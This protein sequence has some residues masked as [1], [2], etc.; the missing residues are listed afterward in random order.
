LSEAGRSQ[1]ISPLMN[2]LRAFLLRP[3]VRDALIAGPST[4]DMTRVLD[5][6]G[7]CLVRIPKGSLGEETTRLLGSLVVARTWQATTGRARLP[8]P[9]R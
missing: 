2:K 8:Q 3:F 4:V 6:G 9:D 5:E 1:V 7:I